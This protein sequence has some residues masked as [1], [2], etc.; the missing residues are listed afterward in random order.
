MDNKRINKISEEVKRCLMDI[1]QN[2]IK[3][4]RIPTLTSISHVEVTRDL[5]FA[6]VYVSIFADDIKKQKALQGLESA[7]GF[8]KKELAREVKLRVMPELIFI[9]DDS[10]E[11]GLKMDKLINEV[12]HGKKILMNILKF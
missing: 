5:S 12:N 10:I 7:K 4:P 9:N 1:V 11:K 2:K 6:K 3:D 8:I